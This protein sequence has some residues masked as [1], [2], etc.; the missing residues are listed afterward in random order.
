M[1]GSAGQARFLQACVYLL[2][3][4]LCSVIVPIIDWAGHLGGKQCVCVCS[5]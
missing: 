4:M 3:G 5:C 2:I 1:R